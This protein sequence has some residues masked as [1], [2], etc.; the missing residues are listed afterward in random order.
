MRCNNSLV[1]WANMRLDA[2]ICMCVF[3]IYTFP[4]ICVS[5]V[6]SLGSASCLLVLHDC[7]L[8]LKPMWRRCFHILWE[9]VGNV[10][11]CSVFWVILLLLFVYFLL[12]KYIFVP[13][14]M[15]PLVEN[16]YTLF[17]PHYWIRFHKHMLTKTCFVFHFFLSGIVILCHR[18]PRGF[19]KSHYDT[20][21]MRI[22]KGVWEIFFFLR[23]I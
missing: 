21:G 2:C 22:S 11:Y 15:C 10:I 18:H 19:W 14:I 8:L 7:D 5:L 13:T 1:G 6:R 23:G 20:N 3:K 16:I 17:L 9:A 4:I 12:I